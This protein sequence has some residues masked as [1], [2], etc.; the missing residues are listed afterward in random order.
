MPAGGRIW[1]ICL[2]HDPAYGGL[3][4]SVRNF[5][6]ALDA[7][8]LSFD[9]SRVPRPA[10]EAQE[11]LHRLRCIPIPVNRD[12]WFVTPAMSREANSTTADATA[13]MVHSLFRGHATWSM[14]EARRRG[15]PY[16]AAPHGSLDPVGM[17]RRPALKRLWMTSTGRSFLE[18]AQAVY[19]A[20]TREM[21]EALPWAPKCRPVV[22][23]WP[24]EVPD[25][26]HRI[27][28][29][30]AFRRHYNLPEDDR[31][32]VFVGRLHSIKRLFHLV[33]VFV[34]AAPQRCR[35]AIV[36]M[37]GDVQRESIQAYAASRGCDRIHVLGALHGAELTQAYLPSEGYVSLSHRENFSYAMAD[38]LACGLPVIL[39]P[40]HYLAYDLPHQ[41]NGTLGCG[42]LLP[43]DG[44]PS[45]VA[46]IRQFAT[47]SSAELEAMGCRGRAWVLANLTWEKFASTVRIALLAPSG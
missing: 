19:F 29:R 32:L 2:T 14:D 1:D 4:R 46:G 11:R 31:L 13:L 36:G 22:V 37:D 26:A 30:A 41:S 21:Q 34:A 45:A 43:D 23:H 5:A 18:R 33:D 39:S 27:A 15:I 6:A 17:R 25:I 42:W 47:A 40:G 12:C 3:Y 7:D 44:L 38:A 9:D 16:G 10:V 24:I 20:S 35:L 8:I 28:V